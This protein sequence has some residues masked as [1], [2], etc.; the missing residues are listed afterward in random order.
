MARPALKAL[1]RLNPDKPANLEDLQGI[2]RSRQSDQL[3]VL[4][5]RVFILASIHLTLVFLYG[6]CLTMTVADGASTYVTL[7]WT[8]IVPDLK[9]KQLT[10]H[11]KNSTEVFKEEEIFVD[12]LE[13]YQIKM[14]ITV[15]FMTV[16]FV[17][18]TCCTCLGAI[19]QFRKYQ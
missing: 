17:L 4:M 13:Q 11:G 1:M 3:K 6:V 16:I 8:Q 19:N 12:N 14:S 10:H 18:V 2:P 7:H 5:R 9:E 15:S